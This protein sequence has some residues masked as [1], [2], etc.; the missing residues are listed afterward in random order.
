MP[1]EHWTTAVRLDWF[2]DLYETHWSGMVRLAFV[3]VDDRADAENLVQDVFARMYRH[4]DRVDDPVA[5]LRSA[6]YNACRNHHRAR[7]VR[8]SRVLPAAVNDEPFGDH[9]IDVVRRLPSR[10]RA[11]VVLRYYAD[12]SDA[13]IAAAVLALTEIPQVCSSIFLTCEAWS[14]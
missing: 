7:R 13:E 8:R 12:M 9:V 14:M 6:V 5:Y 3:L 2:A 10:K 1:V 4:R 11:M